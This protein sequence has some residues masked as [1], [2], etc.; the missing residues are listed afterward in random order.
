V[1]VTGVLN[2]VSGGFEF[3]ASLRKLLAARPRGRHGA[4][5][6]EARKDRGRACLGAGVSYLSGSDDVLC[7]L[8]RRAA[9]ARC[10]LERPCCRPVRDCSQVQ[11]NMRSLLAACPCS[12]CP[13]QPHFTASSVTPCYGRTDPSAPERVL[14][15]QH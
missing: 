8:V 4:W 2:T 7:G 5:G 6:A 9:L 15:C 13:A 1:Q 14:C 11:H 3:C 10:W 12:A